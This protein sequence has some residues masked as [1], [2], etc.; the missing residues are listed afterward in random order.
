MVDSGIWSPD[1]ELAP[2]SDTECE[3]LSKRRKHIEQIAQYCR[4]GGELYLLSVTLRGPITR[5]PWA[6]RKS[7]ASVEK[8][9]VLKLLIGLANGSGE[10]GK[11]PRRLGR[12]GK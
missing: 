10:L 7:E 9:E 1:E 2:N 8:R 12:M 4:D 11:L 5:N 6:R 3:P